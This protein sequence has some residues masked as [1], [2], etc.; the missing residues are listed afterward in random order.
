MYWILEYLLHAKVKNARGTSSART[1]WKEVWITFGKF[2]ALH[3][4]SS[5]NMNYQSAPKMC[6]KIVEV[7]ALRRR[8]CPN[9]PLKFSL[10][11]NVTLDCLTTLPTSQVHPEFYGV[12]QQPKITF[13]FLY[14]RTFGTFLIGHLK[15]PWRCFIEKCTMHNSQS[16]AVLCLICIVINMQRF[17]MESQFWNLIKL[18]RLWS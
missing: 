12:C 16:E 11:K 3:R 13:F 4:V 1:T 2:G 18:K 17:Y 15:F 6:A 10:E 8:S 5:Y 14:T 9:T 7:N